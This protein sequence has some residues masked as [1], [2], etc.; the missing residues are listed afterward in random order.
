MQSQAYPVP[1]IGNRQE[2]RLRRIKQRRR[3][4]HNCDM[5]D[6]VSVALQY[7][8]GGSRATRLRNPFFEVLSCLND[9][10]SIAQAARQLG[11]SYRHLWGY[12]REQ[13]TTLGRPLVIW[14]RGRS[15]RLSPFANKL[16]WSEAR[17]QA[18]LASEIDHL[19]TEISRE[20]TV[21]FND[22]LPIAR[23]AG[24]HDAALTALRTLCDS[25]SRVLLHLRLAGS[26][27]ALRERSA[28]R[29][30]FA[31]V[32]LPCDRPGLA[33]PGSRLAKRFAALLKPGR[34]K[35]IQFGRRTQGL[36]VGAGN[37]LQVHGLTDLR[38][39]DLRLVG[40]DPA[41]GSRALL[42][43][44]LQP[45]GLVAREWTPRLGSEPT[46][47][48]VAAAVSSGQADI[49]FGTESA[50]RAMG[51][52]FI[53]LVQEHGFLVCDKAALESPAGD[54]LLTVLRSRAWQEALSRLAGHD[55]QDAGT[56]RSLKRTLPWLP[57]HA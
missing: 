49:G 52:H 19:A 25:D 24:S 22:A 23:C 26:V 28:G 51:A 42:E 57:N 8:L 10:G 34:E 13:E 46:A 14:D 7:E 56:V 5:S 4:C 32:H 36:I 9:A 30:E 41:S 43:D 17:I 39:S 38:R 27:Q 44:L 50:A 40:P 33:G 53:A 12:L 20:L 16:L 55:A 45:I 29:C 6:I 3:V 11:W 2:Q 47:L 21:A 31:A 48:A 54:A 35:I 1:W 18:R 37:P 15:A